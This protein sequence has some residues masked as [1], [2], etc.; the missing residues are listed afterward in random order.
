MDDAHEDRLRQ[1]EDMLRSLTAMLVKQDGINERLTVS[2]EELKEINA[3]VQTALARIATLL[4][5][6][7]RP[8]DNGRNA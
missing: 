7:L 3:G 5:R 6:R 2:I 4:A 1:H 8:E